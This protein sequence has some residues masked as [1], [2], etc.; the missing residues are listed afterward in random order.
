M[1]NNKLC[2]IF[3]YAPLYRKSIYAAIDNEFDAQ[4]CFS[5][6]KSDIKKMDYSD[7]KNKPIIVYDR[8]VPLLFRFGIIKLAFKDYH[9]YLV[10]GDANISYLFFIPLCHLMGKKVYAWGHGYKTFQGKIGR[11]QKWLAKHF[12][13]YFTYGEGG[14]RRMIDLGI[15]A[16]KLEVIYNSLNDGVDGTKQ[17]ECQSNRISRHFKNDFPTLVFVGRLTEV[18]QLDWLIRAQAFHKSQG[19]NYN[20]LIVGDG[21]ERRKLEQLVK[22][23]VLTKQVWF[24]G[25]C[26]DDN[27]LSV[28]LYNSSLCVSPGNVGLTALHAMSYGTPVISNDDFES[29]MPE[30]EAI[31]PGK[32]GLLYK[33]GDFNDFCKKIEDWLSDKIE[34]NVVRQNCYEVINNHFNSKYQIALLTRIIR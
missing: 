11:F 2:C 24:Y 5:D 34:R 20:L 14:K 22:D 3:N 6:M 19:L 7:F 26:Y 17:L 29:Q 10:I 31:V 16:N 15:P 32:T 21:V 13:V 25:Q 1:A 9:S 27:E 33:K 12:D 30:Y 8:F 28:L 23:Y 4:F 18:K